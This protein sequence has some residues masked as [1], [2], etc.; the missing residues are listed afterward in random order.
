M[1]SLLAALRF[2]TF[3]PVPLSW[4]GGERGLG[5]SLPAFPL[6][7]A[8]AGGVLA[9]VAW[10][11]S[12]V[13]PPLP[14][15]ALLVVA[16]VY[17]SRAMHLEGVADTADGLLSS[18]PRE[19]ALAI[20]KDSHTGA[21]G[22]VAVVFTVLV[23]T[24]LLASAGGPVLWK[25]VLLMPIVGR[26]A[27]VSCMVVLPYARP[28]GGLATVFAASLRSRGQRWTTLAWA[29]V[30]SLGAGWLVAG[31]MGLVGAAVALGAAL[32]F[33]AF[34]KHRLGGYT[35]DTLGATCELAELGPPLVAAIWG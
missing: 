7:G 1:R 2:L 27:L 14:T 20:M 35:G 18:R 31:L 13:L 15:A 28:S 30:A 24:T 23:K 19:Q 16:L 10:G 5:R 32:V 33:A 12:H 21:M 29:V 8:L 11:L 17:V 3:V 25:V 6:V 9:A 4:T 34:C 26:S 22:V